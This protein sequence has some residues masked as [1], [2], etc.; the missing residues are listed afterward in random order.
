MSSP[1]QVIWRAAAVVAITSGVVAGAALLPSLPPP[2]VI[3]A[4]SPAP[5]A[6]P[7]AASSA[8]STRNLFLAPPGIRS[9]RNVTAPGS[10]P[11]ISGPMTSIPQSPLAPPGFFPSPPPLPSSV[12]PLPLPGFPNAG[13]RRPVVEHPE[14]LGVLAGND[15]QVILAQGGDVVVA[16]L[17]ERTRWGTVLAIR[18]GGVVLATSSGKVTLRVYLSGVR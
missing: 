13:S 3:P 14:V 4:P 9:D 10:P 7:A 12:S 17:G 1:V 16:A 5:A 15:P 6:L 11:G 18:P 2:S 8:P